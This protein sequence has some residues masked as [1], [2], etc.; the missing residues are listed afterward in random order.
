MADPALYRLLAWLSPSYPVGAFA[1]SHGIEWMVET[2]DVKDEATLTAWIDDLLSH[3]GPW[4]DAVAFS[5]ALEAGDDLS[6]LRNINEFV[7]AMAPSEERHLETT[8]QG[9]AFLKTTL[10]AWS[11]DG[12]P[13]VA[14]ALG[15]QVAYPV[16]VA[17]AAH[18]HGIRKEDA[19][20]AFL[21]AVAANLVFAGVRL[22][23]LGQ[24]AGQRALAALEETVHTVTSAAGQATFEEIGGIAMMSDIAAMKHETQYTRLF[25]S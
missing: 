22:I 14:E 2:G 7:V 23:P 19:L 18:G 8:A 11:W 21:H 25:R 4:S 24:T 3:G 16:A 17:V 13:T 6:E 15:R 1:Y 5:H 12:G 10:D 20:H 9:N